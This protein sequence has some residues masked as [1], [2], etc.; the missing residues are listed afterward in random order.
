MFDP[1]EF[2]SNLTAGAW[3]CAVRMSGAI[4]SEMVLFK[5][6]SGSYPRR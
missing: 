2:A 5:A 6:A 4:R 1:S 3:D